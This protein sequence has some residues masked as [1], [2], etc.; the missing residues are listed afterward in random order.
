[1][2]AQPLCTPVTLTGQHV[3]LEPLGLAHCDDL[4]AATSDGEIWKLEYTIVPPPDGMMNEIERRL[5]LQRAGRMLPFAVRDLRS[6][7]VIGMSTY[8]NLDASVRR[9]E[10]GSTWYA[11]SAQRTAINTECKLLLL[12]HAFEVLDVIAVEF[13]TSS[14]NLPSRAA[15]ERIGAFYDGTLR[16]HMRMPNGTLRDT[17]VYSILPDEWPKVKARLGAKLTDLR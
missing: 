10:I 4:C 6:G 7:R 5:A 12:R 3:S 9:V 15:I 1:M 2:S 11:R 16:N 13:R 8:T 17:C 14:L